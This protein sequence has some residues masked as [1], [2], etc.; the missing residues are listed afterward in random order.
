MLVGC[1]KCIPK[2]REEGVAHTVKA[3]FDKGVQ[4]TG[5][6]EEVRRSDH[7]RVGAPEFQLWTIRGEFVNVLI[8][9]I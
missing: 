9:G 1:K 4:K 6:V 5:M 7:D 2:V 8:Y 3:V